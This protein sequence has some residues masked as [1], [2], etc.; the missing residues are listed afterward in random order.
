[1]KIIIFDYEVFKYDTLLG[2]LSIDENNQITCK[3]I[4]DLDEIKQFYNDNQQSLWVGHNNLGYDDIILESQ[5]K[6]QNTYK[7]S[8]QIVS[9]NIRYKARLPILTYDSMLG[10]Y[11]LKVTECIVGKNI[12]ESDVDFDTDRPLTDEEKQK[13]E[14]YNLDDLYQTYDNFMATFDIFSLRLEIMKEFSLPQSCLNITGTKL[15]AIC[16]GSK[17]IPSIE[18]MLVKPKIY[19]TLQIKNQQVIDYYLSEGF[20]TKKYIE[21]TLCG[22]KHTIASGGI[23]AAEP[24]CHYDK[25]LYFDVSGYYNLIMILL[26]L[27]PRTMPKESREKYIYMYHEQLRLKKINP[28]KRGVYKTILLAVFGAMMNKYTD[29]YDP[30]NGSLVTITGELFIVDLLEKLEGLVHVVQSNTDGIMLVPFDWNDED[31]VIKIVEEWE[32]RTGFVIKKEKVYNL[33]Q[34]DVN[35]YCCMKDGKVEAKGEIA[36][37]YGQLDSLVRSQTWNG[38][39][40]LII[41]YAVVDYYMFNKLPE[42]TV[43]K[44]K[45]NPIMFQYICK[46]MSYKYMTYELTDE[47]GNTSSVRLQ[48]VNR[49]FAYKSTKNGVVLKHRYDDKGNHEQSRIAGLPQNVFIYNGDIRSKETADE[50]AELIDYDYYVKRIYSR[51][52]EFYGIDEVK[53][54]K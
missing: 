14:A 48:N 3:Q 31:K 6:G 47:N 17:A 44:W 43:E 30:Q 36:G 25:V 49:A 33:W 16:L 13:T 26:D 15:A 37:R 28:V 27:L 10:F 22:T 18:N 4:W 12:H 53:K 32:A 19:D 8:K 11:S 1:M 41:A 23:H 52:A 39:E 45:H 35:C 42:E 20:R 29:F 40:A 38:K 34:R 5:I 7:R 21:V 9:D 46:N 24:R 51:I 50:L 54:F 2:T